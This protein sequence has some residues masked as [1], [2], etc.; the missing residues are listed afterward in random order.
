MMTY[1][2][3]RVATFQKE[4]T[5][6]NYCGDSYF[7]SESD[8]GFICI[9]ADGLGSGKVANE[10]SQTVTDVIKNQ[11]DISDEALVKKCVQ[12]LAGK[13]GAVLGVLRLDYM[14]QRYTYSSIGNISL[15]IAMDQKQRIRT[16]PRPGF[17]GNYERKLK[18]IE[19]DLEENMRFLMF[20]DGV[21]DYELSK[22]CL[23]D[24]NVDRI[25]ET[26]S[27]IGDQV[28]K[29]DTTLIAMSYMKKN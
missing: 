21:T 15:V 5:G 23:F 22:L 6:N 26:F 8:H 29:D 28:R 25:I 3:I 11:V 14:N 27:H 12:N 16:I 18:V 9:I 4:K 7:Y 20:S 13:R 17:L 2:K 24:E 19:G 10:S 1:Q